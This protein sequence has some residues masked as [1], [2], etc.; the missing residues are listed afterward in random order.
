MNTAKFL[1]RVGVRCDVILLSDNLARLTVTGIEFFFVNDLSGKWQSVVTGAFSSSWP[2]RSHPVDFKSFK[3]EPKRLQELCAWRWLT[4]VSE[5]VEGNTRGT[6]KGDKA[7]ITDLNI[8]RI[9]LSW[10]KH[11]WSNRS[12]GSPETQPSCSQFNWNWCGWK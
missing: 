10:H 5:I 7:S 2:S 1:R 11:S 4:F 8:N 12:K 9:S 6:K 3:N